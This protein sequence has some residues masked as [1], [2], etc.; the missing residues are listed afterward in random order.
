MSNR[1]KFWKQDNHPANAR[2]FFY[3]LLYLGG[4]MNYIIMESNGIHVPLICWIV[5]AIP[6]LLIVIGGIAEF[7]RRNRRS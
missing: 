3:T 6:I 1:L 2:W 4:M 7:I 5:Y